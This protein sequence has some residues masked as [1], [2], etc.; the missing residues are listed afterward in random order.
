MQRCLYWFRQDLRLADNPAFCAAAKV[1]LLLPVYIVDDVNAHNAN[2]GAASRCWLHHSLCDLQIQLSHKLILKCGDP[3][4]FLKQL[5]KQYQI[6]SVYWDRCYTPW[7]IKRDQHIQTEL[8]QNYGVSVNTYQSALLFE[9]WAIKN[10]TGKH[11]RIFTPFY[12]NILPKLAMGQMVL[13]K[14]RQLR[15]LV[16]KP[17]NTSVK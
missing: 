13:Q 9:P 2:M 6:E 5:I 17:I 1:G 12:R 11:Y 8:G 7:Q 16:D 3:L 10:K 14:P 4:T 15:F